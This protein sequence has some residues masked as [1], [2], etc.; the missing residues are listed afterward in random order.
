MAT[1][2]IP[3]EELQ[4]LIGTTLVSPTVTMDRETLDAFERG[5][6]LDNA[7]SEVEPAEYGDDL[8]PGFMSLS[9]LDALAV[10]TLRVEPSTHYGVN[11]GF[12]RVR[13]TSEIRLGDAIRGE[14]TIRAIEPRGTDLQVTRDCRLVLQD[15]DQVALVAVWLTLLVPRSSGTA[16]A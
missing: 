5:T 15:D 10:S 8:V 14:F 2:Q 11:Y 9:L 12:D 1:R 4:S 6:L 16:T 7:Y 13:F 3:V